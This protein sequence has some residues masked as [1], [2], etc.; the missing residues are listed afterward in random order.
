MKKKGIIIIGILL[1][2]GLCACGKKKEEEVF[3]SQIG[4]KIEE[5]IED[6]VEYIKL[7]C[8]VNSK[9]DSKFTLESNKGNKVT[10]SYSDK[11]EEEGGDSYYGLK[12]ENECTYYTCNL[13]EINFSF[14]EEYVSGLTINASQI[15]NYGYNT[16]ELNSSSSLEKYEEVLENILLEQGMNVTDK[17]IIFLDENVNMPCMKCRFAIEF[18]KKNTLNT[19][20]SAFIVE[21]VYYLVLFSSMELEYEEMEKVYSEFLNNIKIDVGYS[22]DFNN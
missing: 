8:I 17:T 12:L 9:M 3:F 4:T 6:T 14:G 22:L 13:S 18:D 19:C 21:D 20:M 2:L 11:W 7:K 5:A 16:N 10:F 1:C 15:D